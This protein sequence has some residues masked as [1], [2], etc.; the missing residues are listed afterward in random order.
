[1]L[2][3]YF[4]PTCPFCQRVLGDAERMGINFNLIDVSDDEALKAELEEK[5]GQR[6]VPFLVDE[7]K[8]ISMYESQDIIEYLR[9]NYGGGEAAPVAAKR[10][11]IGSAGCEACEA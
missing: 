1:M 11:E 5:G 6:M 8:G 7:E 2:T 3:L 10:A 9:E 4:K